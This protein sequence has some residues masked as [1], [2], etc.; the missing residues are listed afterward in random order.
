MERRIID[1]DWNQD[2]AERDI[3]GQNNGPYGENGRDAGCCEYALDHKVSE[4]AIRD[5]QIEGK[6]W[7]RN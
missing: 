3:F 1:Q 2:T 5:P 4:V 7:M 6:G